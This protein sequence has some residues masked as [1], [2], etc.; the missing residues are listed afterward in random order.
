M[1]RYRLFLPIFLC[2][3]FACTQFDE[4]AMLDEAPTTRAAVNAAALRESAGIAN[5]DN[6]YSVDNMKAAMTQYCKVMNIQPQPVYATHEYVRFEV[7]DSLDYYILE[8]SLELEM[9]T[10]P[11]DRMLN[12][13]ERSFYA[14]DIVNGKKW[15][16]TVVPKNFRY[17]T[18][19]PKQ[20]LQEIYMQGETMLSGASAASGPST[21]IIGGGST[22]SSQID[23]S[24]YDAVLNLSM[25]NAGIDTDDGPSTASGWTPSACILYEDDL[26]HEKLPLKNVT[27]RVNTFVNIGTGQTDERG[28]VAIPEGWG[29]KFRNRVDYEVK[30]KNNRFKILEHH[31]GAAIAY[32]PENSKSQWLYTITSDDK[33]V[34]AFAAVYWAA[35]HMFYV[36][37][38]ITRPFAN[39]KYRI[40][41][42]WDQHRKGVNGLHVKWLNLLGSLANP[43]RISGLENA[44]SYLTRHYMI[45]TT[46]HELGHASHWTQGPYNMIAADKAVV[47][48]YACAV[49]FYFL[50][51]VYTNSDPDRYR[52]D[53]F[54]EYTGIGE[55]LLNNGF[56]MQDLQ[57]LFVKCRNK[58]FADLRT[59]ALSMR[60]THD[61]VINYLFDHPYN[62]WDFNLAT[63]SLRTTD[64]EYTAYIG[65][66]V[67]FALQRLMRTNIRAHVVKWTITPSEFRTQSTTQ[68]SAVFVFNRTATYTVSA[69]I[70][71]PDMTNTY[72]VSRNITV[73]PLPA[74]SGPNT[75][76][77]GVMSQY[78]MDDFRFFKKWELEYQDDSGNWV[79]G[80]DKVN[81]QGGTDLNAPKSLKLLFH[82]F[83]TF[84]L[85]AILDFDGIEKTV[86]K[87]ITVPA[88]GNPTSEYQAPGIY[89]VQAYGGKLNGDIVHQMHNRTFIRVLQNYV[90]LADSYN[91]RT[92]SHAVTQSHPYADIMKP[93]YRMTYG[94]YDAYSPLP[95]SL[96]VDNA[97]VPGRPNYISGLPSVL[98]FY[99]L[100]EQQPGTVPL[101]SVAM[102]VK[103]SLGATKSNCRYLSL[104]QLNGTQT[105]GN[106]VRTYKTMELL[107]YVYPVQ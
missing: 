4:E 16:Y 24:L 44:D 54:K 78:T 25:K 74:I 50:R 83:G 76:R 38:T 49:E 57:D 79:D 13:A 75:P 66:P 18:E 62:I 10:Y 5:T 82:T 102:T 37:N 26:T 99:V 80:S 34:S 58:D 69:E 93:I 73:R 86:Y 90:A 71:L 30:F 21:R 14:A 20:I 70:Q 31:T 59:H 33:R 91:F 23:D 64:D 92:F 8:D 46:F 27:V 56:T 9:F 103:T 94:E 17:P 12:N 105:V 106:E 32:G 19:M 107:G 68:T 45:G 97:I 51:E 55:A 36:Q 60:K 87:N 43:V 88:E 39:G 72:T 95:G 48:S 85:T 41:V 67:E 40:A 22:G 81:L 11:L 2:L 84:R 6:P 63:E 47:E 98:A 1:K 29:G 42:F 65:I 100:S 61:W 101:Y 7:R 77:L 35:Y 3:C 53:Y 96:L 89:L 52:P 104:Q 28:Y 15:L